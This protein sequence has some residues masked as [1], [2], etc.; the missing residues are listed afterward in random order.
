MIELPRK[1][2]ATFCRTHHIARLSVFGSALTEDFGPDSD[3]D[4]LVEFE[5]GHV[6]GLIRFA[7]MELELTA[8]IGRKAD[9]RTPAELSKYFRDDVM[10]AAIVQYAR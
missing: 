1:E 4:F 3:V 7:G 6:P 5:P 2:I 10:A 9:L 8:I